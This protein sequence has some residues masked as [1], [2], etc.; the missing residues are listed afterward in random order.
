MR[1][2]LFSLAVLLMSVNAVAKREVTPVYLVAGQSNTDGRVP[3]EEL[4]L[5]IQQ[6]KYKHCYWSYG[7]G[8]VSGKGQF[9]IFWPRMINKNNPNRWAYD[10]VV[11]YWLEQSLGRNFYVIKE[12]LGGTAIDTAAKSSQK[13][14]WSADPQY[15][16]STAAAD[17]GGKSLLKAFT[18]N[19][20]A[21]IDNK[22][23]K[24]K[25]GY[26]I[27]ALIWHQGESDRK[28][29]G[30]Y[31]KN[32]SGVVAYI[33]QYLVK[34]TGNK[35]YAN[36]PVVIGGIVFSGRGH[37]ND[38]ARAQ[39]QLASE[40]KNIHYID[41][42]DATLRS[43]NMH[44]DAAGA[45]LLGRKIYNKLASLNL[46]G[47]NAR[48]IPYS[49]KSRMYQV[50]DGGTFMFASFPD[51]QA[52][53]MRAVVACPGGG[54]SHLAITHEGTDWA[55]FFNDRGIAY[56]TLIY[57]MPNGDR[58]IPMSDVEAAIKMVR[59]S[60]EAWHVSPNAIGVM[61]SSAGGH[62]AS[63]V[64]THAEA[65]CRPNFQIL[66]YPVI[67]FTNATHKG[68]KVNF[69]GNYKDDKA[70]QK[71]F[72]NEQQVRKGTTPPAIILLASDDKA[73]PALTNGVAYYEALVSEG[74]PAALHCY[75]SGGHGFGFNKSF[76]YHDQL[77][78]DI[79][80]WLK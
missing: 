77:L 33:R 21:C 35:K 75:P 42:H 66:F 48:Q 44:F 30:S 20:G 54:Y 3:N 52:D 46:A 5:Y 37:A 51:K 57:R 17:K 64:A 10:A 68:S 32:I 76:K 56:F 18:D 50:G 79:S 73:V 49:Q 19:I 34:K 58:T 11:N 45:E 15:L 14:Y 25:G 26:D 22:L 23:S 41:V 1:R 60:A 55:K 43:D 31:Y 8:T 62:L 38:V 71:L 12:S 40:D 65:S 4:P 27:K 74:I 69:L 59:D 53:S 78:N 29:A 72:S 7:S 61:G 36:L 47:K 39:M 9:E 80:E 70:M 13:M 28:R 6:D 67:T 16:A 24:L 2:F 63:T